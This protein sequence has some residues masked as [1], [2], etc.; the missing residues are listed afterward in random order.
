MG[1]WPAIWSRRD[2]PHGVNLYEFFDSVYRWLGVRP[3][4]RAPGSTVAAVALV[5]LAM[6][7]PLRK[8]HTQAEVWEPWSPE[9]FAAARSSGKP[10]FVDFTAAWCL[11]CQVNEATVLR[12][13]VIREKLEKQ[14]FKLLKADWTQYDPKITAGLASV[15][16]SGVPTY[17]IYPAGSDSSA[18]VL[19]ELLTQDIVSKA[20][21]KDVLAGTE[22]GSR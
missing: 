19:P 8:S 4:A 11:S 14:H 7:F 16:R 5:G 1:V 15:N 3:L 2:E 22:A 17:V 13:Q 10:V 12:S 20:I 21:D 9:S 6:V 18:H